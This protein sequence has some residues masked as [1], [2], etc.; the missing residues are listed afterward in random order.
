ML[1]ALIVYGSAYLEDKLDKRA[2]EFLFGSNW[3]SRSLATCNAVV[4]HETLEDKAL[5]WAALLTQSL[6][7]QCAC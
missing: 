6:P 4:E 5:E 7:L 3:Y 2:R 1:P